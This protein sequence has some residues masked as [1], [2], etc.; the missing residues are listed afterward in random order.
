MHR[1]DKGNEWAKAFWKYD[2]W[3]RVI[4]GFLGF[5]VT[6]V[7]TFC[8]LPFMFFFNYRLNVSPLRVFSLSSFIHHFPIVSPPKGSETSKPKQGKSSLPKPLQWHVYYHLFHKLI[9]WS[10][11]QFLSVVT[12]ERKGKIPSKVFPGFKTACFCSTG[13][14]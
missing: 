5:L 8:L 2:I 12:E 3:N 9:L 6:A 4:N 11:R 13:F 14:R 7:F 1:R 10:I